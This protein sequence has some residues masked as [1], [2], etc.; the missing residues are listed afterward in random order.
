MPYLILV[1][2]V[3]VVTALYAH[4]PSVGLLNSLP[5]NHFCRDDSLLLFPPNHQQ[6]MW[7]H[8][9]NIFFI[10]L[11]GLLV[12]RLSSIVNSKI[13]WCAPSKIHGLVACGG[14]DGAVECFDMR[15]K[16]F[17]WQN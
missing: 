13:N 11:H 12:T 17:Y 16:N 7:L 10:N 4:I 5:P 15:K 9:G 8:E 14:E 3:L 6:Y 2:S 1:V